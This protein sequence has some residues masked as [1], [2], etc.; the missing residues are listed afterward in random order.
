[1]TEA[2]W[3]AHYDAGVPHR[4]DYRRV[5][6]PQILRDSVRD[7][8]DR[9]AIAFL[10][11]T[12]TYAELGEHVARFAA[13]LSGLG[14][15]K[16][17]RVAIQLPNLPQTVIAFQAALAIGAE[18]VMTN[19]LYTLREIEHQWK[20][21]GVEVAVVADFLWDQTVR[22]NRSKLAPKSYVIASIPEYLRFP[23]NVLAPLKLKKESPPKIAKVKPEPGVHLF[24]QLLQSA[25]PLSSFPE[26]AFE[27]VAVLQ[28]TGGTTGLSKGA[29]LTHANLSSNVQQIDAWFLGCERGH[30]VL[31]TALPLFHVFGL[32]VCMSWGL[33]AGSKLVLLAN[34]RDTKSLVSAVSKHRVTLFPAVPALFNSLNNYPGID[35][36]DVGCVKAC[37]S[38]SAPIPLD[39]LN[40]F[41]ELTGSVIVEGFG[42]S[43]T[44]PV[45]HVNP[46]G[47]GRRLG[48]VGIPF[49]DTDAKIVDPEDDSKELPIGEPGELLVRGP[50]VMKGYWQ[51][52][53]ESEESLKGGWMHT[54]DLATM[55]AD[56]FFTI[57]G[58]KKDMINVGG[59]KV[60]PDE[61]DE[62][63]MAHP[64]ILEAATI[65]VPHEKV[66]ETVKS[67][68]VVQ[69]GE[70]LSEDDV[71]AYAKQQL[72][73]YKVPRFVEF[74]DEL[75]KST[76][77]KVLRRELRDRE[78]A[79]Q[80]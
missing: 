8:G 73:D 80:A 66:G 24:K 33:Y 15:T 50:Q 67:F 78:L 40:R 79:K 42:M 71:V 75:P 44:S 19:P 3:F 68:V 11:R 37:F 23:L 58:R 18:V 22:P 55:D 20:D 45:T 5:T 53:E 56:G 7:Y 30:E 26:V 63:L 17:T 36:M 14:V 51:R 2:V 70:T 13:A 29:M 28:Y 21:A 6:L 43:E 32:T 62:V 31:L 38:G 34:P 27:D 74:M 77:L 76:V 48:T 65:G 46:L 41:E 4:I 25:S 10:N 60:F 57:V 69:P 54:G 39:V 9:P 52:P 16:G 61:V 1:M 35:R 49:P 47:G 12:M 72:T 64:K 59:M